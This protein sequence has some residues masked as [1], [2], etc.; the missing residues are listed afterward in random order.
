MNPDFEYVKFTDKICLTNNNSYVVE[1]PNWAF[2]KQLSK[3]GPKDFWLSGFECNLEGKGCRFNFI[4][5]DG[6]RT[7]QNS[8]EPM[9]DCMMPEVCKHARKVEVYHSS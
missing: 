7:E 3:S 9:K 8:G 1:F 5:S 4:C 2:R 6:K